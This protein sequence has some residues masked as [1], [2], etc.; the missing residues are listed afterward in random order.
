M[1]VEVYMSYLSQLESS[2][3]RVISVN[4]GHVE[5]IEFSVEESDKESMSLFDHLWSLERYSFIHLKYVLK[6]FNKVKIENI[7]K[8]G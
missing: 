3:G 5:Y 4:W 7:D 8:F 6:E 2:T 1:A